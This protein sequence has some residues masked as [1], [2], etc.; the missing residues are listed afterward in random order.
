DCYNR[1]MKLKFSIDPEL[2]IV[3]Q[4][5]CPEMKVMRAGIVIPNA[6][7]KILQ[8]YEGDLQLEFRI[9][10]PIQAKTDAFERNTFSLNPKR[11][12]DRD[13]FLMIET[14]ANVVVQENTTIITENDLTLRINYPALEMT[15]KD[16][17]THLKLNLIENV[18]DREG[19]RSQIS[20]KAELEYLGYGRSL[21]FTL[22]CN[23]N[24]SFSG[25]F[26]FTDPKN[27]KYC[28]GASLYMNKLKFKQGWYP[29]F[30]N[31]DY[32]P[33]LFLSE[34]KIPEKFLEMRDGD[35][36]GFL[37]DIGKEFPGILKQI[38]I[39]GEFMADYPMEERRKHL[40]DLI[41][42]M[43]SISQP[44]EEEV[45]GILVITSNKQYYEEMKQVE[46][47]LNKVNEKL[48]K[49]YKSKA[50][51]AIDIQ[52]I[53]DN[54]FISSIVSKNK[55]ILDHDFDDLYLV[56][57]PMLAFA[58][59]PL[60]KYTQSAVLLKD[61]LEAEKTQSFIKKAKIITAIGTFDQIPKKVTT[62]LVSIDS[63]DIQEEIWKIN[64]IFKSKLSEDYQK[65][66]ESD[67][68]QRLYP[69][70][71]RKELLG[72]TILTSISEMDYSY[73]TM[74]SNYAA[75]KP[76]TINL[77]TQDM[78]ENR[79]KINSKLKNLRFSET[80]S[81]E[82]TDLKEI[83]EYIKESLHPKIQDGLNS[84][85]TIIILSKVPIPFELYEFDGSP[86][87]ISKAM[88]RV[89]STDITDTSIMLTL[90]IMR[91]MI[92]K[93]G[94]KV[95]VIAPKYEGEMALEGAVN[96]AQLLASELKKNFEGKIIK[97]I[98][99]IIDKTW[100]YDIFQE[101]LKI[102]HFSGH[103]HF[104][105]NKSCLILSCREKQEPEFLFPEDLESFV[106]KWGVIRGYP[107]VFTSACITGQ[108]QEAGSGLEGLAAQFIKSGATCFI[109]TLWEIMDDSARE[110][111]THL[112]SNLNKYDKNLGDLILDSR[113]IVKEK[114]LTTHQKDGIF[115]PTCYAFILFG[116]PTIKLRY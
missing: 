14:D 103:G 112:Y 63:S 28:L 37:N 3:E 49:L 47:D 58:L 36:K 59:V 68:L 70:Y 56:D 61:E 60:V 43:A 67:L 27:W 105:N 35:F 7:P 79:N 6:S 18:T 52:Y 104:E 19:A 33:I 21:N 78:G 113:R 64:G 108:I 48:N 89:C 50:I 53:N 106:K 25:T 86:L 30:L 74:A 39:F 55:R 109:G 85:E 34:G 17:I 8:K 22:Y 29:N 116:D 93:S 13:Y 11:S 73:L 101:S 1:G 100:I 80:H 77:I 9:E 23:I 102:I 115:D 76:A 81:I 75:N 82:E 44:L 111:A 41:N 16:G 15:T 12:D 91:Q 51:L 92:M 4:K 94:E 32:S 99:E 90:N 10:R 88:G 40:L 26:I 84:A 46:E 114:C 45:S 98:D 87:C 5:A 20:D 71:T 62:K 54:E 83:G 42:L 110:F 38:V 2:K 31:F 66:T 57:D 95:V 65:Y 107:L 97:K 72:N 69:G 24:P 96:E